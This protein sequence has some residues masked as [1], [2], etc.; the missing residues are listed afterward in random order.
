MDAD[1][2]EIANAFVETVHNNLR[3]SGDKISGTNLSRA[4]SV[5][6]FD[7]LDWSHISEDNEAGSDRIAVLEFQLRKADETITQLRKSLTS[8][9]RSRSIMNNKADGTLVRSQSPEVSQRNDTSIRAM[10]EASNI[11]SMNS[12]SGNFQSYESASPC[13]AFSDLDSKALNFIVYE[14]LQKTGCKLTAISFADERQ[15]Q[16]GVEKSKNIFLVS[17][18]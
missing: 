8:S 17:S 18:M 7:S 12:G 9:T 3:F 5:S 15:D 14:Y 10:R 4:G 13:Y 2:T 11:N 6:T 16:V 1:F